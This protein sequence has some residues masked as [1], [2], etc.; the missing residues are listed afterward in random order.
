MATKEFTIQIN[1]VDQSINAVDALIKRLNVLS[2]QLNK[3]GANIDISGLQTSINEIKDSLATNA[4]QWTDVDSKIKEATDSVVKLEQSFN[5]IVNPFKS[6]NVKEYSSEVDKLNNSLNEASQKEIKPLKSEGLSEAK[7]SADALSGSLKQV[8]NSVDEVVR[9]EDQLGTKLTVNLKGMT[10]QFDDVDQ[11]IG[12][13]EDKLKQLALTGQKNS[14]QFKEIQ[15]ELVNLKRVSQQTEKSI[16]TEFGGGLSN[17]INKISKITSFASVGTG[18]QGLFNVDSSEINDVLNKFTSLTLIMQGLNTLQ[19]Q[20]NQGLGNQNTLISELTQQY[21]QF[22]EQNNVQLVDADNLS[23]ELDKARESFDAFF[24]E[25]GPGLKDLRQQFSEIADEIFES[26]NTEGLEEEADRISDI[27]QNL[28]D[29]NSISL[30]HADLGPLLADL[31]DLLDIGD[32]TENQFNKLS[33]AV[34]DFKDQLSPVTA[35]IVELEGKLQNM[36]KPFGK[37]KSAAAGFASSIGN[38]VKSFGP[39]L[40]Q[41]AAVSAAIYALGKV[42]EWAKNKFFKG[43]LVD[44]LKTQQNQL[45]QTDYQLQLYIDSLEQ[46]YSLGSISTISKL[47]KEFDAYNNALKTTLENTRNLLKEGKSL[48]ELFKDGVFSAG[49]QWQLNLN[50]LTQSEQDLIKVNAI[51]REAV[52]TN[53]TLSQL[54]REGRIGKEYASAWETAGGAAEAYAQSTEAIL[55]LVSYKLRTFDTTKATKEQWDEL[56]KFINQEWVQLALKEIPVLFPKDKQL[57]AMNTLITQMQQYYKLLYGV[58]AELVKANNSLGDLTTKYR[59]EAISDPYQRQLEQLREERRKA[60]NEAKQATNDVKQ[61]RELIN[62]INAAFDR[63]EKDA[64]E[65]H[66]KEIDAQNKEAL[67]KRQEQAQKLQQINDKIIENN[68]ASLKEGLDKELIQ[69]EHQR[70]IELR[71]AK[72]S[73]IKVGEQTV[74]INK[75][76]DAQVL[77][78]KKEFY[79]EQKDL[80]DDW[81]NYLWE[82]Q[83]KI[84]DIENEV[85]LSSI[86]LVAAGKRDQLR[87]TEDDVA[88]I[89][90]YH[91]E[92]K[93]I[94]A[95]E[96]T[97]SAEEKKK[98]I[99]DLEAKDLLEAEKNYKERLKMWADMYDKGFFYDK[100][101]FENYN[102]LTEKQRKKHEQDALEAFHQRL[103]DEEDQY[104]E[105]S[106]AYKEKYRQQILETDEETNTQLK[107]NAYNTWQEIA[108]IIDE[109]V[110]AVEGAEVST[111]YLGI[112]DFKSTKQDFEQQEKAL[113][114]YLLDIKYAYFQALDDLDKGEISFT[115]FKDLEKNLL[116]TEQNIYE[117]FEELGKVEKTLLQDTVNSYIQ[118][119]SQY[120]NILGDLWS[121]FNDIQLSKLDQEKQRLEEEYNMLEEAYKKQEELTQKHTDKLNDIEDELKES[122]GDRRQHLIEQLNKER[123]AMLDSLAEEQRIDQEKEETKKKQDAIEKKRKEQEKKNSIVQ[124]MINT[125]TAVTN[126]LAVQPFWV[127]VA[128][129]SVALAM[130]LANVAQI[131]KQKYANGGLLIGNSHQQGGIPVGNTGIEVEGNE[132]V[133]NK[134]STRDNLPLI[135]YINKSRR[136]LTQE[137]IN[138]FF[139][140][141]SNKKYA[142][143]GLL[144]S[145]NE[146]QLSSVVYIQDDRPIVAQIVDIVNSADNYRQIRVLSGLSS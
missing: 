27:V 79:Q 4:E 3:L 73:G 115:Q 60:I 140:K 54:A 96:I 120:V 127:G 42:F 58:N 31:Q 59:I 47:E 137:D 102:N 24:D 83:Q 66:Q 86:K 37:M 133:V 94:N 119:V 130:G 143:G 107:D 136:K 33:N 41:T 36:N 71:E 65:A 21:N 70:D 28:V 56:F 116:N 89:S 69:I 145:I 72:E 144:P 50:D 85:E 101:Y 128:L 90:A 112:I 39:L 106:G 82:N 78:A 110:N 20:L 139:D 35:K 14:D 121:T 52:I 75:K 93:A 105:L 13:L 132:Y 77:K 134:Q 15:S 67:A 55:N 43:W 8:K 44:S 12:V 64:K 49:I 74:A 122:R 125:F 138:Q 6:E 131:K 30:S 26:L 92:L 10:L 80:L 18:I 76:Y 129:S 68:I 48:K 11:A 95:E 126:A 25:T 124:A 23:N 38:I 84:R 88:T 9:A 1:G 103:E 87:Y 99:K 117:K 104:E 97:K 100:E 81:F 111:N 63:R 17:V 40:L 57:T 7:K 114:K 5:K 2:D 113:Q 61:Q 53:K 108:Q 29:I 146:P 135:D 32:L 109:G 142:D 22:I 19:Q 34:F 91:K 62:Q 46:L 118:Y 141:P 98:K 16:E 51:L 45:E 123:E